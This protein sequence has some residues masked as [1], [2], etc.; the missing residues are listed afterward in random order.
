VV[1]FGVV[2]GLG[3]I[4]H[5]ISRQKLGIKTPFNHDSRHCPTTAT[6]VPSLWH[7]RIQQLANMLRD[8]S[9]PLKLENIMFLL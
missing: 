1:D 5:A 6:M 9:M 7:H 4:G 2:L 8:K 3:D